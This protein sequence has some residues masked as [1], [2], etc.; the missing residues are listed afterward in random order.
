MAQDFRDII[1]WQKARS[2]T[3]LIYEA[4]ENCKDYSYK[5]QVQRAS[6]SIMNNIA[7]GSE[8]I[9]DKSFNNYLRIARGSSAEIKSM[10]ILGF[11]RAYFDEESFNK[12]FA[13]TNEVASILSGFMKKLMAKG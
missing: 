6:V 11:D 7:E 5:D 9:S 4:L 8:R 2:L 1:A 13:H 3:L 12:L 10:L